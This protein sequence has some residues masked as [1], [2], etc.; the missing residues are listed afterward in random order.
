MQYIRSKAFTLIEL[1]VVIAII[2]ILAAILFPVF[3]QAKE[4]AKKTECLSN[5]KNLTLGVIMY[6]NDYDDSSPQASAG[7]SVGDT[8][9][10]GPLYIEW[11]D[12]VYPYIKNGGQANPLTNGGFETAGTSGIFT[13]PDALVQ[14]QSDQ[15]GIDRDMAPINDYPYGTD[16]TNN[17]NTPLAPGTSTQIQS[18]AQIFMLSEKGMNG[19]ENYSSP[20]INTFGGNWW[21]NS[22]APVWPPTS[23]VA[24]TP[25]HDI[26][27]LG[28]YN[29]GVA[30]GGG[31]GSGG[32]CD[33]PQTDAVNGEVWGGCEEL[34]RYR[35]N[36][37]SNFSFWDGHARGMV[38]GQFNWGVN[39][40]ITGRSNYYQHGL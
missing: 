9:P 26:V 23:F 38:K 39:V 7:P 32:N 35:H 31:A 25:T 30:Q 33:Q 29:S 15:Y 19:T 20:F 4:A 21:G 16:Y 27:A 13:C 6:M 18:P 36:N 2:A 12:A 10:G 34:P 28:G 8:T 11:N 5:V 14:N 17:G 40:Y 22:N 37:S 1:L 3:A 24:G